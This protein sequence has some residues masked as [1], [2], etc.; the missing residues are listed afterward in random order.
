LL[1]FFVTDFHI[2][3]TEASLLGSVLNS[4]SIVLAIPAGY[5]ATKIGWLRTLLIALF[6]Y[7]LGY[8]TVGIATS[9]IGLILGFVI[10]G[11]G[12][13]VFHPIGFALVAKL[14][15]KK[16]RGKH[17]V[18]FTTSGEVGKI[19]LVAGVTFIIVSNGWRTTTLFASGIILLLAIL[20]FIFFMKMKEH[21]TAKQ[22]TVTKVKLLTILTHKPFICVEL[23]N[24]CDA[25]AS[26]SLFLFLPFLLLKRGI[27][28]ALL[29]TFTAVFFIGTLS[30]SSSWKI[31]R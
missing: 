26:G 1:H 12:F 15:D 8:L 29:G 5:I 22:T 6:I 13:G 4:L 23:A 27:E 30:G 7:G 21:F 20:F 24:F 28:P 14:F 16:T 31:S 3:L 2:N 9:Y 11:I 18:D 17:M 19:A 25:F 10:A